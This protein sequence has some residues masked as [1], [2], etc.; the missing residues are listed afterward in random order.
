MASPTPVLP[1]VGS[2][3]VPPGRSRPS[4]S[5][6]S[7]IASPMRS[8]FD[9][10]GFMN[11]SFA[12][13]VGAGLATEVDEAHDRRRADE[14]ENGRVR[15]CHA[16]R[17]R[18]RRSSGGCD[19]ACAFDRAAALAERL[20]LDPLTGLRRVDHPAL[21]DVDADVAETV[22]EDEV[23]RPEVRRWGPA[24]RSSRAQPRCA[25]V[26]SRAA[27]R[28][29]SRAPSSR[30]R[31]ETRPRRRTAHRAASGRASRPAP[32][33]SAAS[34][35]AGRTCAGLGTDPGSTGFADAR[36]CPR[37]GA[38]QRTQANAN[39]T[40]RRGIGKGRSG[41][42]RRSRWCPE[43]RAVGVSDRGTVPAAR[44]TGGQNGP[45][46]GLVTDAAAASLRPRQ[47]APSG[48]PRRRRG[49]GGIRADPARG[50]PSRA[51]SCP[52]AGGD[53]AAGI[54]SCGFPLREQIFNA[55]SDADR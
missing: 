54:R 30:S 15:A 53:Q 48:L 25:A 24:A 36:P 13:S 43:G 20:D 28:P 32:R 18:N 21:A 27:R 19:A 37:R 2:T 50:R 12:S 52:A 3:I 8:L 29:T 51:G 17:K 4:R 55:G 16:A 33:A 1:E 47:R 22:E 10:P 45:A 9:P 11:S 49:S 34:G 46:V 44:A 5:A 38:P 23:A 42:G 40:R 7:I 31:R 26:G 35:A 14:V 6:A 41:T 39:M